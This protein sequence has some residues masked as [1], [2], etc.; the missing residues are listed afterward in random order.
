MDKK[1]ALLNKK[2]ILETI[3]KASLYKLDSLIV[4]K[5]TGSTNDDAK[6]TL[7]ESRS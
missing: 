5:K 2:E 4:S 3:S 6:N 1:I 7:K